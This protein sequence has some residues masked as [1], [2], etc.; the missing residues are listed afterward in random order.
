VTTGIAKTGVAGLLETGR[1]GKT[2]L[3]RADMDALPIREETGAEFSSTHENMM[4]ACGH[5]GNMAMALVAASI[6]SR[7]KE[8]FS[9]SIKFMFQPADK[10]FNSLCYQYGI[11]SCRECTQY[12]T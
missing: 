4:H 9:G 7:I 11:I 5:D 1:P 2:L 6:L 8:H 12:Y 10:S 3:I